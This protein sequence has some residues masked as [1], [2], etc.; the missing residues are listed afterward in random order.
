MH[1]PSSSPESYKTVELPE[2]NWTTVITP[3][4]G[5]F[6][7]PCK[8]LWEYR[9]L[10]GLFVH[11]DCVSIYKQT[12]LGSIWHLLQPLL[13]TLVFVLVFYGILN[14]STNGI[15]PILFFLS[16]L[17]CWR[18]FSDCAIKISTTF[19]ANQHLFDKIYFPRLVVPIAEVIVNLVGFLAQILVFTC[20]YIFFVLKGAAIHLDWRVVVLPVL[21]FEL[22]ALGLGVGCLMAAL[23]TRYR[24]LTMSM[25][26]FMQLW[27]YASCVVYPLSQV[28][29]KI[30]WMIELNPIVPIIEAF[31]YAFMGVGDVTLTQIL[32]GTIISAIVVVIGLM[33]FNK[34]A[35]MCVDDA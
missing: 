6:H 22:G 16:G 15:P 8:E 29:P 10:I 3:S 30:R 4:K 11:R 19:T 24:D 26:F 21:I 12:V 1:K 23:T 31:R 18:Y 17:A 13:Q 7:F 5:L 28:S 33:F 2:E 20:L 9:E 32:Y 35:H 27:M 14:I 25:G 34:A